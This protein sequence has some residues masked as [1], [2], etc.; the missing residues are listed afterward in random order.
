M[1]GQRG[2]ACTDYVALVAVVAVLLAGGVSAASA[3]GAPGMA[4]AVIGRMRLALCLVGGSDC[5]TERTQ[6][7]VVASTRDTRHLAA[8]ILLL[9]IDED[10]ILLRERLSDGSVR[11]ELTENDGVGIEASLGAT[12]GGRLGPLAIGL[13]AQLRAALLGVLGHGHVFLARDDRQ[14][15]A[16]V[17][18]L[19]GGAASGPLGEAYRLARGLLGGARPPEP[20]EDYVEGGARA[21][22]SAGLSGVGFSGRLDAMARAAIGARRDR[23][24]GEVTL[25]LRAGSTGEALASAVLGAAGGAWRADALLELTLDRH[26]R[27]VELALLTSGVLRGGDSMPAS[28]AGVLGTASPPGLRSGIPGSGGRWELDARV[29]LTDPDVARAWAAYRHAPAS[30]AAARALGERMRRRARLDV[31]TYRTSSSM[32]G[33]RGSVGVGVKLG[34]EIEHTI[35]RADLVAAASRPPGG[36]WE[37]RDDCLD[38]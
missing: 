22:A 7:C 23:H 26:R 16:I 21:L 20:D 11:L 12:V 14:A 1:D 29:D 27:P 10:H 4:N 5:R 17:Q 19:R 3:V 34:G 28:L 2:Q 30:S 13:G 32:Q 24:T 6:P 33:F 18:A 35:D 38:P 31:R 25:Y 37:R 15:D 8:D 9:R 36:V